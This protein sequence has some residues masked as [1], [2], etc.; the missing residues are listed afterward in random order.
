MMPRFVANNQMVGTR[1]LANLPPAIKNLAA[2]C[3]TRR[4]A[5]H[6]FVVQL[7]RPKTRGRP[8]SDVQFPNT[9]QQR[10]NGVC[11]GLLVELLTS[12]H[13]SRILAKASM[14][15]PHPSIFLDFA[16]QKMRK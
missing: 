13:I 4:I 11:T 15:A 1:K 2:F 12:V 7:G 3:Q 6:A 8:T 14:K 10:R 16:H 9:H 5:L